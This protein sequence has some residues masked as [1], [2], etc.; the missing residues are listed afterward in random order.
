METVMPVIKYREIEEIVG[1]NLALNREEAEMLVVLLYNGIRDKSPLN[2]LFEGLVRAL[3]L[4]NSDDSYPND[5]DR[6][7]DRYS[8]AL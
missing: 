3:T 5:V 6:L 1:V 7:C 4:G 8:H 2:P